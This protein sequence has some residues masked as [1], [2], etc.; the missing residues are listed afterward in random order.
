MMLQNRRWGR[1]A[2]EEGKGGGAHGSPDARQRD[3]RHCT[4][5]L[6][7]EARSSASGTSVSGTHSRGR[8][9]VAASP[10]AHREAAQRSL[11]ERRC[12]L[13]NGME[14][15]ASLRL[16]RGSELRRRNGFYTRE[17]GRGGREPRE[18]GRKR[19]AMLT[20]HNRH[21]PRGTWP[22]P[23]GDWLWPWWPHE[24]RRQPLQQHPIGLEQIGLKVDVDH[25]RSKERVKER[26]AKAA[27]AR[28]ICKSK[29]E[30]A[31]LCDSMIYF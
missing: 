22:Q 11:L 24:R 29:V 28:T 25:R 20:R 1:I 4:W 2:L 8:G 13:S 6:A 21:R 12:R 16:G 19:G 9:G 3:E 5:A 27:M 14:V 7:C 18:R 30:W 23:P 10:A 31:N 15:A 26:F 17:K